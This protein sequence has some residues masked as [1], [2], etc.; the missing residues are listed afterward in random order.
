[1]NTFLEIFKIVSEHWFYIAIALIF[2]PTVRLIVNTVLQI[3]LAKISNKNTV[4]VVYESNSV[5]QSFE[6]SSSELNL[7]EIKDHLNKIN[8]KEI[9]LIEDKKAS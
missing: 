8:D 7:E 2:V 3:K 6:V 5:K 4:R 1:M 9:V